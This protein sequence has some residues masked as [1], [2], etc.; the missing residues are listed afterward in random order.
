MNDLQVRKIKSHVV[1]F[2]AW[3]AAVIF[4]F[5][6]FWMVLTSFKTELQAIAT[7]PLLV[8]EPTLENYILINDRT[9]YFKYAFNSVITSFGGT[10][11]ARRIAIPSS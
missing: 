9:D 6:I 7:P 1:V 8:F 4:F 5:P 10:R 2:S 11:L 3:T